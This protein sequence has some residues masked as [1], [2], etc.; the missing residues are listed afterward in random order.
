MKPFRLDRNGSLDSGGQG[1]GSGHPPG[2]PGGV[3]QHHTPAAGNV[4]VFLHRQEV[5][6][7]LE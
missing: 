1:N 3:V 6:L 4:G 5:M 2:V 7:S